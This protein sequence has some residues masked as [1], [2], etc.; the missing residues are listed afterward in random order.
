MF[1]NEL[2]IKYKIAVCHYTVAKSCNCIE[3]YNNIKLTVHNK[4]ESFRYK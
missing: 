1:M 4:L 3:P 2:T